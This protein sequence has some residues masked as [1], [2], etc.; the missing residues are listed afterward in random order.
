M[1]C[2][3]D[4]TTLALTERASVEI[5]YCPQC[6]GVWLDRGELDRIIEG[7][8]PGREVRRDEPRDRDHDRDRDRDHDRDHD[9]DRDRD[10]DHDRRHDNQDEHGYRRDDHD[11]PRYGQPARKRGGAFSALSGLLGGGD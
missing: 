1:K 4:G 5:D 6:R 9:H 10:R 3:V 11:D 7:S 8:G 2:P